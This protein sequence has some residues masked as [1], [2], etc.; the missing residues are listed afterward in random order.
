MENIETNR[1]ENKEQLV[2]DFDKEVM[3]YLGVAKQEKSNK[4]KNKI[5]AILEF[6]EVP[7]SGREIMEYIDN[8]I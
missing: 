5:N 2:D 1:I 3:E 4:K 7:K 8:C 6:C